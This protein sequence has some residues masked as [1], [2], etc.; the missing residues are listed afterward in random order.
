MSLVIVKV[1]PGAGV[2][3]D[4]HKAALEEASKA[5][6][7]RL[8]PSDSIHNLPGGIFGIVL[9]GADSFIAKRIAA[10]LQEGLEAV[11]SRY[12]F[13]FDLSTHSLPGHVKSSLE[14]EKIVKALLPEEEEL[15]VP[16]EAVAG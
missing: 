14:L 3:E 6:S 2:S 1:K 8:R 5:L 16:A 10:R 13:A 11:Q 7:K 12:G 9:V 4:S 15:S